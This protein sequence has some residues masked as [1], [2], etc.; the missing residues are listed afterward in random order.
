MAELLQG[1]QC[2]LSG[3]GQGVRGVV[4][5]LREELSGPR[6]GGVAEPA[7]IG[8]DQ[9]ATGG[10]GHRQTSVQNE[11]VGDRRLDLVVGHPGLDHVLAAVGHRQ[12]LQEGIHGRAEQD[13]RA[14]P[15]QWVVG[16]LADGVPGGVGIGVVVDALRSEREL[17]EPVGRLLH[18]LQRREVDRAVGEHHMDLGVTEERS[19]VGEPR[20]PFERGGQLAPTIPSVTLELLELFGALVAALDQRVALRIPCEVATVALCFGRGLLGPDLR[21]RPRIV[22]PRGD[23]T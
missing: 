10:A 18:P 22:D 1:V 3:S 11:F 21:Q 4:G 9:L 16:R 6:S 5:E 19:D 12:G 2:A 13:R 8:G 20:R 17:T 14:D 23:L 7:G 15:N